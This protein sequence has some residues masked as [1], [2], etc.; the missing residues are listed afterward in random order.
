[1]NFN[2]YDAIEVYRTL[3]FDD[4]EKGLYKETVV[5]ED[6]SDWETYENCIGVEWTVFAHLRDGGSD[7]ICACVSQ[8]KAKTL[9]TLFQVL[10][11]D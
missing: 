7:V 9:Q 6:C 2:N 10:L 3:I 11:D 1:M 5:T 4:P 8:D